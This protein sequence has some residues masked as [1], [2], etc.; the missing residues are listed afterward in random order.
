V[1]DLFLRAC[2]RQPVE[3][4]PIWIM[5]Q[6]GRYLPEY[7]AVRERVGFATLLKTPELAAEVTLQPVVR[8]GLDAAILF[9]DIL[10]PAEAMG[11]GVSFNP[12]PLLEPAVRSSAD[13]E[14]LRVPDPEETVAFVFETIRILRRDLDARAPLIGF[15]AAP[16]TLAAYLV[17]G[18]GTKD[19]EHVRGMIHAEP[20][21]AHRLLDK[22]TSTLGRYLTAQVRAGAQAIQIFDSWAGVLSRGAYREFS[23]PYVR[24]LTDLLRAEGAPIIY[25]ALDASHLL[26]EIRE[27][28]ADVVSLDWRLPL[29]EASSRLDHRFVLQGNLDP[30]VLLATEEAIA[31]EVTA[32]LGEGARVPGHIFNL[33]HGILPSTPVRHVEV[34]VD[35][36]RRPA[37]EVAP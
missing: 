25:F 21:A 35:A 1:S 32:V 36:V 17:E 20:A 37:T 34:L 12:G 10:V 14:R 7:R 19:F 4:T 23:L 5:R 18:K 27:S 22:A 2:R 31:R 13:V 3:R 26:E 6:A 24:R 11:V 16:F 8:F 28:G 30:S 33:G 29:S 9:S 15:G